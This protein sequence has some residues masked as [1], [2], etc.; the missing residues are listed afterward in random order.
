[1]S[2][3]RL[4][5]SK[6]MEEIYWRWLVVFIL[7]C[8]VSI[9][10][11]VFFNSKITVP[12]Q[13]TSAEVDLAGLNFSDNK[14]ISQSD[15]NPDRLGLAAGHAYAAVMIDNH[16]DVWEYQHGL[17]SSPLVY[18]VPVEGG[19]NRLMALFDLEE[20][21][22]QLGP[23]RSVRPYFL[24]LFG[25]YASLLVHVGGSP[26]ALEKVSDLNAQNLN[27]MTAAGV[28]FTRSEKIAMPHNTFIS[29]DDI[30]E[31]ID[32]FDYSLKKAE[33]VFV[34]Q[35]F[36]S[37][38]LSPQSIYIDYSARLTYDVEYV[39]NS[40][41]KAYQRFRA[42]E[43]QFDA[44]TGQKILVDNIIIQKVPTEVVLDNDLRIALD[45]V[46]EGEAIFLKNN[47]MQS[48]FWKKESV[49]SPTEFVDSD[50]FRVS[51]QAGNIWIEVVPD[52]H[53]IIIN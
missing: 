16:F 23:I 41:F 19:A 24:D 49:F 4:D 46:G 52:G 21:L 7:L 30:R 5:D 6:K 50:G 11:L 1:M 45:V 31:G 36:S 15:S 47:E 42:G 18:N 34:Y 17:S 13:S 22:P 27:E 43:E 25:E 26:D 53:D 38:N 35:N 32:Y 51:F 10:L 20:N 2:K 33:P 39:Y 37:G 48:G 28:F 12:E 9:L 8:L 40:D 44:Q 3:I 14:I 29:I